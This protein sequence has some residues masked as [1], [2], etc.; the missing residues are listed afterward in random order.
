[1]AMMVVTHGVVNL[2]TIDDEE[3]KIP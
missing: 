1:M 3:M 2:R